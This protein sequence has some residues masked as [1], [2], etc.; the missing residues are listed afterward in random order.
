MAIVPQTAWSYRPNRWVPGMQPYSDPTDLIIAKFT[1]DGV[2]PGLFVSLGSDTDMG[3]IAPAASTDVTNLGAL[4]GVVLYR[5]T[6]EPADPNFPIGATIAVC[7]RGIIA[8][9]QD[10]NTTDGGPLYI[11]YGAGASSAVLGSVRADAGSGTYAAVAP[12]GCRI[13]KGSSGGKGAVCLV[14]VNLPGA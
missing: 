14:E 8:C 5:P 7:R 9:L 3:C 4:L 13:Y 12:K 1:E 10:G 11:C 2:N 6:I